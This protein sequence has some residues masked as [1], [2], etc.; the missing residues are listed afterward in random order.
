MGTNMENNKEIIDKKV[1]SSN[2]KL[3]T[4]MIE[5]IND[6]LSISGSF[7]PLANKITD[8][9]ISEMTEL[10]NKHDERVFND[11]K[12]QRYHNILIIIILLLFLL[13]VMFLFKNNTGFL[14]KILPM[15]ISF[16]IGALGGYGYGYYKKDRDSKN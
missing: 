15:I 4:E 9:N 3:P 13:I 6:F 14:E 10:H 8:K 5:E 7:N 16:A 11:K 1:S 2:D 12:N